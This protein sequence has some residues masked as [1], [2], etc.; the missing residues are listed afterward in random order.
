MAVI[1]SADKKFKQG[2]MTGI[3]VVIARNE[4]I[5]HKALY[6]RCIGDCFVPRSDGSNAGFRGS[7]VIGRN[8]A[9]AC[10]IDS[11][12]FS[13]FN[14]QFSIRSGDCFVRLAVMAGSIRFLKS[15]R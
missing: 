8:E 6:P 1:A 11:I 2:K 3:T 9:I 15:L 5:A 14:F 13:I 7:S 12:S 10:T 4:A